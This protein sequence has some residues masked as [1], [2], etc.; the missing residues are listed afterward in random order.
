[1]EEWVTKEA[2]VKEDVEEG[3]VEEMVEEKVKEEVEGKAVGA[4][5]WVR[6]FLGG[7]TAGAIMDVL[8]DPAVLVRLHPPNPRP[9]PPCP[10]GESD[11]ESPF[12]D[13][14]CASQILGQ[15]RWVWADEGGIHHYQTP[16]G[17]GGVCRGL[18]V[19][20]GVAREE[21]GGGALPFLQGGK[22]V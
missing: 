6:G 5:Q 7:G 14:A 17:G 19:A 1:M 9:P 4:G 21:E 8:W 13:A 20:P 12:F 2:K 10:P 3:L 15:G 16:T 11:L 18:L 22:D